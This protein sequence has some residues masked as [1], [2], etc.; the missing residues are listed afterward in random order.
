MLI[1]LLKLDPSVNINVDVKLTTEKAVDYLDKFDVFIGS[2]T[3]G[4]KTLLDTT[5]EMAETHIGQR[6]LMLESII[7]LVYTLNTVEV[8][9]KTFEFSNFIIHLCTSPNLGTKY[10]EP[11]D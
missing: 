7:V 10:L 3:E 2:F 4:S 6:K 9:F 1:E 5:A 11:Q 8:L